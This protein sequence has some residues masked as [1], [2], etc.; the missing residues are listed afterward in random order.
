M[1]VPPRPLNYAQLPILRLN[2]EP[3]PVVYFEVDVVD[4]VGASIGLVDTEG[5]I[6]AVT[7][8]TPYLLQVCD[9]S[10]FNHVR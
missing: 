7:V 9:V 5:H 1:T 10:S 2:A 8:A 6:V 4:A 3:H